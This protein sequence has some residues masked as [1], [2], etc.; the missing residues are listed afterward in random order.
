M[1]AAS[2]GQMLIVINRR[3]R[4]HKPGDS[5]CKAIYANGH[6]NPSVSKSDKL[7][8]RSVQMPFPFLREGGHGSEIKR[9]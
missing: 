5:P 2:P 1:G 9:I 3:R 8:L 4:L 6:H 7:T